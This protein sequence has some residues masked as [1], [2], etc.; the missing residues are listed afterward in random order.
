MEKVVI[1]G[2]KTPSLY[3]LTLQ[4]C[5]TIEGNLFGLKLHDHLNLLSLC[6]LNTWFFF[7]G[8][9]KNILCTHNFMAMHMYYVVSLSFSHVWLCD[10]WLPK[11][12]QCTR[13]KLYAFLCWITLKEI[14]TD[15]IPWWCQEIVDIDCMFEKE[16]PTS[17]MDL[18]VHI[19]IH[20]LDEV[21]LTRMVSCHWMLFLEGFFR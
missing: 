17:F 18:Q 3:G 9:G 20:L 6:M 14:H 10:R 2:V 4:H 8:V 12:L 1:L 11:D 5:F 16:L 15:K 21:E 19:L 7:H 13:S